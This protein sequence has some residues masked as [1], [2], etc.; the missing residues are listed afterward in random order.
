M[1]SPK[2][3][4]VLFQPP[5]FISPTLG[6]WFY[7]NP[8][9]HSGEIMSDS[10]KPPSIPA[11]QRKA[12]SPDQST[13]DSPSPS[14]SSDDAPASTSRED[15][16]NQA[17][18]F[19]E[20]ESIRD[21]P[22][23]RKIAFLES[24][25]LNSEEINQLLGVTR[26]LEA[27]GSSAGS[28]EDKAEETPETSFT[29]SSENTDTATSSSAP[30]QSQS[31]PSSQPAMSQPRAPTATSPSPQAMRN[32]PPIITYPEFL[33]EANKPP[34]LVTM[35][36]ILYTLYGAAGIGASLYGASEFLVKPMVASLTGAR[37]ELADTAQ[38]NLKKLNEKLEQTVSEIPPHLVKKEKPY[39]DEDEEKDTDSVTSDP[40]ELFHRDIGTQTTPDLSSSSTSL[41]S[42]SK[43]GKAADAPIA[44][45]SKHMT[46]LD[47]IQS[48]LK[49]IND[50]EK[51]AS[52]LD[53]TLRSSLSD[54]HHYLDGLIYSTPSYT[55]TGSYGLYSGATSGTD[56]NS[57]GSRKAEDDAIA[58]FKAE[59]RGV[60][61]ALLSARNF[62][63]SGRTPRMYGRL[64]RPQ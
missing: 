32:E 22:T 23:D 9:N 21:S 26:N 43:E 36:G 13:T 64:P 47:S 3:G 10:S 48:Q 59:I 63:S 16:V 56:S 53:D 37:H 58:G 38:T 31:P 15:L 24:K 20:D 18:R 5:L 42:G 35:Q 50:V 60:K 19:L 39:S 17:S 1:A 6:F 33:F 27:T 40:T 4:E 61:G 12:A 46:R 55:A 28:V 44:A 52:S 51:D 49:E 41:E 34:P 57:S 25:G 29:S 62:P 30:E 14:P 7:L 45:V 2:S 54:L 8:K 11:W